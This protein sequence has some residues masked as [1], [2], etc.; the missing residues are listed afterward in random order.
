[1]IRMALGSSRIEDDRRAEESEATVFD[2]RPRQALDLI[3]LN[4]AGG[5]VMRNF[6]ISVRRMKGTRVMDQLPDRLVAI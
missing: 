1:M 3:E 4:E 2:D 6:E 5:E